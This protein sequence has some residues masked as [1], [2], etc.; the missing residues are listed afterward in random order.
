MDVCRN[1]AD[2]N[3][4]GRLTR[5]GFAIAMHLILGK[6][7]GKDDPTTLPSSMWAVTVPAQHHPAHQ[8]IL[9]HLLTP[10]GHISSGRK[11]A[12]VGHLILHK[13]SCR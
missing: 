12:H 9:P 6:L 1:F 5:D 7:A 2:L 11:Y 8:N 4:D 10:Q 13:A 3:K